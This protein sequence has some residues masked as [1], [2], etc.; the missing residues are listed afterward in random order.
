MGKIGVMKIRTAGSAVRKEVGI[1]S[2]DDPNITYKGVRVQTS[3]GVGCLNFVDSGGD[4]PQVRIQTRHSIKHLQ[5]YSYVEYVDKEYEAV[6]TAELT[7]QKP[8]IWIGDYWWEAP[9]YRQVSSYP[10][11]RAVRSEYGLRLTSAETSPSNANYLNRVFYLYVKIGE[12][13]WLPAGPSVYVTELEKE[14][15][16]TYK[17]D[18]ELNVAE[19]IQFVFLPSGVPDGN[20]Y[21]WNY[22]RRYW[23]MENTPIYH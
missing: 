1:Y 20:F 22:A 17:F 3:K 6:S 4:I 16:I 11:I 5:S 14:Y 18:M 12:N 15:T 8:R 10:N 7:G 9:T 21:S 13:P 2:L 19:N 23:Y